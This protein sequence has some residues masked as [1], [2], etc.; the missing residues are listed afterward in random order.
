[1]ADTRMTLM[2]LAERIATH[3]ERLARNADCGRQIDANVMRAAAD[4][5]TVAASLR[6]RAQ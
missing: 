6:A 5:F 3:G 4:C 2:E 1:M